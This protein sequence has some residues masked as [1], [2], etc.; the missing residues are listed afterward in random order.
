MSWIYVTEEDGALVNRIC[1]D[2]FT[3]YRPE[4]CPKCPLST[5]C[6]DMNIPGASNAERTKNYEEQIVAKA[7]EYQN[8]Q[9]L[10]V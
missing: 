10:D 7:K 4:D 8:E 6:K 5:V 2:F 3:G 9:G 1:A